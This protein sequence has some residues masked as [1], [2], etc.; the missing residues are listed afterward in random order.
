MVTRI[1]LLF[2]IAWI[3]RLENPLFPNLAEQSGILS[4]L[5]EVSGRDL[6]LIIGGFFLIGKSTHE[7]HSKL[8]GHESEMSVKK[9]PSF[10][11]VIIQILILDLVFS[12][13]SVITAVGMVPPE[14]IMIMILSVVIAIIFM[15]IFA[16][17]LGNFVEKHPTVKM[18]ALSFLLLIGTALIADGLHHHIPKG[19]IY[20]AMGFSVF[21]EMLNLRLKK[22]KKPNPVKLNQPYVEHKDQE[23]GA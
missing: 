15:M 16:I 11:S 19:Y 14:W 4:F 1:L 2:S 8:E 9:A 17:P 6:I 12:L 7:I 21:V 10:T 22:N 20:S 23:V 3:I 18:L 5:G 13:D